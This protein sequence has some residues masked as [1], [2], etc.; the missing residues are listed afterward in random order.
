MCSD[1]NNNNII[2]QIDSSSNTSRYGCMQLYHYRYELIRNQP[3][4]QLPLENRI[5][6]LQDWNVSHQDI[7]LQSLGHSHRRSND[8]NWWDEGWEWPPLRV[9]ALYLDTGLP[10]L[11]YKMHPTGIPKAQ[12]RIWLKHILNKLE[13]SRWIN[14]KSKWILLIFCLTV[15]T[16]Y[17][18]HIYWLLFHIRNYIDQVKMQEFIVKYKTNSLYINYMHNFV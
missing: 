7:S 18:R 1:N 3:Y 12:R 10:V 9:L 15:K 17:F 5:L 2:I 14:V 4:I 13:M 6:F 11:G 8:C 16:W